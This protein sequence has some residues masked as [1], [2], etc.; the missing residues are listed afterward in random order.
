MPT[1]ALKSEGNATPRVASQPPIGRPRTAEE[2]AA[3]YRA[4]M[5]RGA[6]MCRAQMGAGDTSRRGMEDTVRLS[7]K[8]DA[9]RGSTE[10]TARP[11]TA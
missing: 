10:D 11:D 8:E 7:A 1:K 3:Q 5:A 6:E 2:I 9:S 4:E